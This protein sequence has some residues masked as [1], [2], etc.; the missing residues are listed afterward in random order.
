MEL[1]IF[2]IIMGAVVGIIANSKGKNWFPWFLYGALIWPVALTHIIVTK[3]EKQ[4]TATTPT[5]KEVQS[6]LVD[7]LAK[8]AELK[9]KGVIT[10]EEFQE[11]KRKLL[12]EG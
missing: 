3:S 1:L 12:G 6:D 9:E 5:A 11:Q 2:W 10:E 7:K 8:L 4:E